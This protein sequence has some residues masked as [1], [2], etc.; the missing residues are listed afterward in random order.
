[1][2]NLFVNT[3]LIGSAFYIFFITIRDF[4]KKNLQNIL[5]I[6][7]ILV[8]VYLILSILF[9]NIF[10]SEIITNLKLV[11]SLKMKNLKLNLMILKN[12]KIKII[13]LLK[14]IFLR[15]KNS[16]DKLEPELRGL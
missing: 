3:V 10:S 12:L 7:L 16:Q 2:E 14:V 15:K 4:L 13:Y 6:Y 8:L 11:K 1:M 9:N 5:K